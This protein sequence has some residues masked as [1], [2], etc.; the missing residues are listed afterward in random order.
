MRNKIDAHRDK[1]VCVQIET[2]ENLHLADAV[3]L[4][5]DYMTI[6]NE[7]GKA[8]SPTKQKGIELL[9]NAFSERM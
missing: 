1:D 7:L 6:I 9:Q 2:S 4:I 5:I 3:T 8:V